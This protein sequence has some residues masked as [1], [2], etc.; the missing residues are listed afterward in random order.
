VTL[1]FTDRDPT[2]SAAVE[3]GGDYRAVLDDDT[4]VGAW[5]RGRDSTRPIGRF[6]LRPS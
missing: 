5:Y 6:T 1:R 2:G 3:A 4:I